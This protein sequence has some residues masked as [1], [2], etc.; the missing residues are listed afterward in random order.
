MTT[1]DLSQDKL[2]PAVMK[3]L[4]GARTP[5]FL[6]TRDARGTPNV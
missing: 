5:K 3:A 1:T 6:A 2:S 4:S